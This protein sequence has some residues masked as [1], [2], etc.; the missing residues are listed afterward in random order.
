MSP[1]TGYC[2]YISFCLCFCSL[3]SHLF[4]SPIGARTLKM[5][6][7]YLPPNVGVYTRTPSHNH[8]CSAVGT[9]II[10]L[11]S[12][13]LVVPK[14]SACGCEWWWIFVSPSTGGD[15]WATCHDESCARY[16]RLRCRIGVL[17]LLPPPFTY[18]VNVLLGRKLR[19]LCLETELDKRK[20]KNGVRMSLS[21]PLEKG[22]RVRTGWRG[23]SED[24]V[25]DMQICFQFVHCL[26]LYI[27]VVVLFLRWE[28]MFV[29]SRFL[30]FVWLI[31]LVDVV[32]SR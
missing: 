22:D 2:S 11:R 9:Q 18:R 16:S 7:P 31:G 19:A 24:R 29:W 15:C 28:R 1:C 12:E 4:L 10:F 23:Q 14:L 5:P 30:F 26:H 8:P 21:I 13:D 32:C 17:P 25:K 27:C 6:V 20:K 3:Q